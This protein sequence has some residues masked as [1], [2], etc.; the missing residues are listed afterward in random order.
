MARRAW[1]EYTRMRTAIFFLI[2]LVILVLVGSFVPQ[3][4]TSA[5]QKVSDFLAAHGNVND[6]A[7]GLGL[8]LTQVFVS[9]LYF[10]LLGSLYIAL[11]ACVLRRGRALVL[12]TVRHHPRTA[13]YWGEWGSWLFHSAFFVLLVAVVWGKATGYQGFVEV[14]TG[15]T[16]TE[17][18]V[19]EDNLKEGVLSNG[20]HAGYQVTLNSFSATYD[21]A[22][23]EAKDFVSN[24]TVSDHGHTVLTKD[25]RVNDFL[26]YQNVDF[27]QFDYGWAPH[28]VVT[29]P[30]GKVVF[31][32]TVQLFSPSSAASKSVQSGTLKVPDFNYTL[33]GTSVST[34]FG[35]QLAIF[36]DAQ[37]STTLGTNG[38]ISSSDVTYAP[39]GQEA[40][41]PVVEAK[42]YVGNLGLDAGV[43]QNVNALNQQ[44]LTP[45]NNGN[46]IPLVM[47]TQTQ[48]FLPGQSG[49]PVAFT[50]SFP[51]LRQYSVFM[52]KKDDG[53]SM[54]YLAFFLMMSGLIVKLYIKPLAE[55]RTTRAKRRLSGT[56]PATSVPTPAAE[57]IGLPPDH[58]SGSRESEDSPDQ[59]LTMSASG[60]GS[61]GSPPRLSG[62]R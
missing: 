49:Q 30:A 41:N 12:R 38:G 29:N 11:G 1:R 20:Q 53:V 60:S 18:A 13:Q 10:I 35:A 6:L 32:G 22:S 4:Q 17:S 2:G 26:G 36:P 56:A 47:G 44:Q 25:V 19:D 42:L 61:A 48:V 58:S 62:G 5:A 14:T 9:P 15:Q 21:S 28:V 37:V 46:P 7:T 54:V 39:G 40:R 31:D 43:P 45:L 27:Y 52:V 34:Q 23:G 57:L 3:D 8:P 59:E 50:I 16:V 24:V 55:A 51:D 33:P